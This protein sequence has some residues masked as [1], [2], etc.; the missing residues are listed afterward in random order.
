MAHARV[1][2]RDE[3]RDKGKLSDREE[4]RASNEARHRLRNEARANNEVRHRLRNVARANSEVRRSNE[5]RVRQ[6][7][8]SEEPDGPF[9]TVRS[10]QRSASMTR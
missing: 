10:K 2:D 7:L 8:V 1:R 4:V 3:A 5:A 6:R 9:Q